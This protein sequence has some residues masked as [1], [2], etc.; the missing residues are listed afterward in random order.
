LKN[1]SRILVSTGLLVLLLVSWIIAIS[2]KSAAEKQIDLMRQA[3][4]LTDDGIYILAVPLLEEA[5]GY[6]AA[7]TLIAEEALKR[8]YLKLFNNRSFDR[9]YADLL[10]KQMNR[11]DACF[12]VFKEAANYYLGSSKIQDALTVLKT[13]IG[14]TGNGDLIAL[15]EKSRYAYELSRTSYDFVSAV[16]GPAVQV[17]IDGLWGLANSDGT[18]LID[19][20]YEK[21]STFSDGRAIVKKYGEVYAIDSNNNRVAKLH[22]EATDIGNF[23]DNR[24]P[25]LI[26]GSWRRATGEFALGEISFQQIGMYSGGY[27]AVRLNDKWGVI[28]LG[29]NWLIPAEYDAIIQDELGRC[30]AQNSVFAKQNG[31][32]YLFVNGRQT[33]DVYEDARPF[34]DEGYA[35][36]RKNGKW[37]F[38][39]TT[40]TEMIGFTFDDAL[41]FGQHLA[42]VKIGEL[43]GYISI[44]GRVVIDPVFTEAKSFTKGT[45]PVL[46]QSGWQFLTL[47][48]YKKGTG[49]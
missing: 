17:R 39:D 7:H 14:K 33:G 30:Y 43:W 10:E 37:G 36:V 34:T 6:N 26:D 48:E 12:E 1:H 41:S 22:W 32:V 8:V 25:L 11:E 44:S 20:E 3:S 29:I 46:T 5:A 18:A 15:Y 35:A 9:K 47:L 27:A 31:D 21:I 19:C 28:D 23:S 42:A 13:G 38:I 2:S 49:L 24:I 4:M 45:A 40:G 16:F